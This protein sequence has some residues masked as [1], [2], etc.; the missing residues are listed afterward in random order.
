MKNSIDNAGWALAV[1]ALIAATIPMTAPAQ[2][3]SGSGHRVT[4]G[5][6]LQEH[7]PR[8]GRHSHEA[9]PAFRFTFGFG[10]TAHSGDREHRR[11]HH[12]DKLPW[13]RP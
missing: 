2:A 1:L 5:G 8:E 4:S 3:A 10:T 12:H 11:H 9:A 7:A 13:P 6:V